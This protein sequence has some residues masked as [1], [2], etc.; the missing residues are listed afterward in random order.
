VNGCRHTG[1]GRKTR[2]PTLADLGQP[3]V[4]IG[5]RPTS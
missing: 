5:V 1:Q 3:M 2:T 4:R